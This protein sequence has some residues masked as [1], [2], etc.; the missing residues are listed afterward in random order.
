MTP[1]AFWAETPPIGSMADL[2]DVYDK[3]LE[4]A[5]AKIGSGIKRYQIGDRMVEYSSPKELVDALVA[6]GGASK[7]GAAG[8]STTA[9]LEVVDPC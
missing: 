7:A 9:F 8:G 6:L 3:L 2:S 4:A 1:L 5:T